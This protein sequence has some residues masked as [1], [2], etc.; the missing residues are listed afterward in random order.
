MFFF[1]RTQIFQKMEDPD[2]PHVDRDYVGS[3][4]E[5]EDDVDD[6]DTYQDNEVDTDVDDDDDD[7]D[8]DDHDGD[9]HDDAGAGSNQ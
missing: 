3:D 2:D 9:D 4:E 6:R 5:M 7:H 8:D 1:C